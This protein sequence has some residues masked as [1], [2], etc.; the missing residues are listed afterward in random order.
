MIKS[1]KALDLKP[2]TICGRFYDNPVNC[3]ITKYDKAMLFCGFKYCFDHAK[4]FPPNIPYFQAAI[5]LYHTKYIDKLN[6]LLLL[7]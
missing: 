6:K 1:C 3:L 5:H 7:I 2:C 4:S